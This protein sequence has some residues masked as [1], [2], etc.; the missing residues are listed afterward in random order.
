MSRSL[1]TG[2]HAA[3]HALAL[4]GEA[5]RNARGCCAGA[6]PITPQTEIIEYLSGFPFSKG[7]IVLV[8]SEH[9]AMGVCIGAA[10]SGARTFTASS[11]NG[12]AY[13][14]ENIFAAGYYRLPTVMI[15]VNRTLGPP[16]NIWVDQGDSLMMRDAAWMQFYCDSHQDLQDTV[17]MAFRVAEDKRVMLPVIVA[18]DGF[19]T[20]HTQM[21]V[22]EPTQEQVDAF[23]PECVIPHKL[24]HDHP[25][26]FG[27]MTWPSETEHHRW[28]IQ[29]SMEN[30]MTVLEEARDEFEKIFGRRPAGAL[31]AFETEDAETI[32]I[33]CNTMAR[34]L[35]NVV[36]ERRKKGE[37]IGMIRSKL[38]RPFPRKELLEAIGPAK[39][40]A[41]LDRNHSPGSGGIFWQEVAA[42]LS[43][44]PDMLLQDYLVGLG[45]GD[46]TPENINAII[47]DM[48]ERTTASDPEWKDDT[49]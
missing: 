29:H 4:A 7:R 39:R 5:N 8:E 10:L 22:D 18:M 26:T 17:L 27:G 1:A 40:V 47:D 2:N 24:K 20:S 48:S 15:A 41:V 43:H 25:S 35:R 37:K 44:D 6:Y 11:S 45:G 13:M 19:V 34:T 16:W 49:A 32:F 28:E 21:V 36:I 12:L 33:A 38:F 42:T 3:G 14:T 46:V 31:E 30:A 23:L 9:S